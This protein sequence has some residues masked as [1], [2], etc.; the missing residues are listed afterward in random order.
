MWILDYNQEIAEST[1]ALRM[2]DYRKTKLAAKHTLKPWAK[3]TSIC[4]I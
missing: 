4:R 2:N 3:M 1:N